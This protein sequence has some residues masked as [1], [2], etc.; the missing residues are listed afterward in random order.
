[1]K[2]KIVKVWT[3]ELASKEGKYGGGSAASVVGAIATNLA[4]YVFELQQGKK[5]YIE[6]EDQIQRAIDRSAALSEE[7]L[8]LAELDADIFD[9]VMDLFK[10]PKNTEVERIYRR[11]KI[12]QGLVNA[13]QP[14][15]DI[16]KKMDEVM[17]LFE[18][19]I[20]LEVRGSILDDI[21]VGLIFAQAVIEA[22]KLNCN[23]NTSSI[24]DEVLRTELETEVDENYQTLVERSARLKDTAMNIIQNN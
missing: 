16:M 17:D 13:A 10:L 20:A 3:Q 5:K 24:H 2:N 9:P 14:P 1:M 11:E 7:L 19:L 4:Q 15:L 23:S 12:D 6:Q 18:E 8:D 21:A 22:G